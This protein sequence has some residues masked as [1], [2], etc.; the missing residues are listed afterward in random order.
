M[1]KRSTI[2]TYVEVVLKGDR[3]AKDRPDGLIVVSTGK[4]TWTALVEAK[5]GSAV[6]D[7]EQV[8]RYLQ[9][10]RDNNIDAVITLSNQFV[11]RATH[12]PV[13]VSKVLTRRVDLFHWSWKF[14]LTEALLLQSRGAVADPAQALILRE[15]I[16]FLSHDSVGVSGFDQMPAEWRELVGQVTSGAVIRKTSP[17]AEAVVGA[18]HQESRD[19]ALRVS[20]HLAAP[21]EIKLPRA[22]LNDPDKRLKDDCAKLS[23][24]HK[25]ETEYSVPNAASVL[26]VEADLRAKC[27]RVGMEV[28]APQDREEPAA[29]WT[30]CPIADGR[31]GRAQGGDC[32]RK[33]RGRFA[34]Y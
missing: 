26:S 31:D 30:R 21:I 10:A 27:I 19:L 14:V 9:L 6:L 23:A 15:F 34:P 24:K 8:Q 7:D 4:N 22:H 3:A 12:S 13:T 20:Q 32:D 25:L 16:R 29:A 17:E 11:S 33:P 28:D 1:G 18:W 2:E 5:I